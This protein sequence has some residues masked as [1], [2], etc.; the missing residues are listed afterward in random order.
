M[1]PY[2]NDEFFIDIS[3]LYEGI[4]ILQI[5]LDNGKQINKRVIVLKSK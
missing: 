3:T 5:E 4:H 2:Q 1:R